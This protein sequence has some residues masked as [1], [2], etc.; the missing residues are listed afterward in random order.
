MPTVKYSLCQKVRTFRHQATFRNLLAFHGNLFPWLRL[1]HPA[2]RTPAIKPLASVLMD[3]LAVAKGTGCHGKPRGCGMSLDVG[4]SEPSG[5][6]NTL[7]SA[8]ICSRTVK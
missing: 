6:A 8:L 2:T 3:G 7:R 4:K 1:T 5:R